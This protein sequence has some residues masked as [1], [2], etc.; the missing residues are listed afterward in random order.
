MYW[1]VRQPRATVGC[2]ASSVRPHCALLAVVAGCWLVG[3]GSDS[4]TRSGSD[5]NG[6]GGAAAGAGPSASGAGAGTTPSDASAPADDLTVALFDPDRVLDIEIE[7]DPGDW[8]TLRRQTRSFFD[9][10]GASCL[11]EPPP[12]PFAYFPATVTIDGEPVSNVGVRKKGFFGSLSETKPSL[13]VKFDEYEPDQTYSGEERLT[14]NNSISDE[15]YIKQCLGYAL[16]TQAGVSAPR[17]NFARVTVNGRNLGLYVN[18]ESIKKRFLRRHFDDDEGHLYEGAL[19]DFRPGWVDTF[20]RKTNEDEPDDRSDLQAVVDALASEDAGL[21]GRIEPL[22]D[23]EQFTSFWAAEYLIMHADGYARNTNNFYIYHDPTSGKFHFIP[24]GIDAI[25]FG[26]IT[27]EWEQERPPGA[28]W[29]EGIL[30]RRLYNTTSSRGAYFSRLEDLLEQVWDESAL[31]Q[32]IDRMVELVDSYV[33]DEERDQF[34]AAVRRVSEFVAG[35]RAE[36]ESQ[37]QLRPDYS[38]PLRDPWCIDPIGQVTGTF[39]TTWS[40][41]EVDDPFTNGSGTLD[42][43][44]AGQPVS[45]TAV[46]TSSGPDEESG[47]PAVR[48]VAAAS[49]TEIWVAQVTVAEPDAFAAAT[50]V[51]VD[52]SS[53]LGVVIKFDLG[54][55]EPTFE[56]AGILGDGVIEFN[57][58]GTDPG[59]AVEGRLLTSTVY[60]AIF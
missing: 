16:F 52:W 44:I 22:V 29:A 4:D 42:L 3:C 45:F 38:G 18:V 59:A 15:S 12:S 40:S 17:C 27:L 51:P 25:M 30:A 56:V 2:W 19:S 41:L 55:A 49:A 7:I 39:A 6:G 26:D 9:L 31:G 8:D 58:A 13:K 11:S 5:P 28:V 14:L 48:F 46:G 20:E 1:A 50:S 43:E 10:L 36:I 21:L 54:N 23:L 57:A 35:R 24:W 37:W 53:A 32:E 60:E 34:E 47:D 33:L